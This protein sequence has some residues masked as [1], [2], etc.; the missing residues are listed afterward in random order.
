MAS[1]TPTAAAAAA[2]V[3]T[4]W[5]LV[6]FVVDDK[7]TSV[8]L[9]FRAI[10]TYTSVAT[11]L[12]GLLLLLAGANLLAIANLTLPGPLFGH[13]NFAISVRLNAI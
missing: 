6:V 4:R 11:W 13:Y 8:G 7:S 12:L 2:T 3:R 1:L 5:T 10:T 9:T